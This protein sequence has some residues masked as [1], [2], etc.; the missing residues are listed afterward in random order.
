LTAPIDVELMNEM[1]RGMSP[2]RRDATRAPRFERPVNTATIGPAPVGNRGTT[3]GRAREAVSGEMQDT[4]SGWLNEFVNPIRL[5]A[6]VRRQVGGIVDDAANRRPGSAAVGA[7]MLG[8]DLAMPGPPMGPLGRR[9]LGKLPERWAVITPENPG[10]QMLSAGQNAARRDALRQRLIDMGLT[11]RESTGSYRDRATGTMLEGE[12]PF[13]IENITSSQAERLGR[14]FDQNAVLTH[15]GYHDLPAMSVTPIKKVR[16]ATAADENLTTIPGI[17]AMAVDLDGGRSIMRANPEIEAIWRRMSKNGEQFPKVSAVDEKAAAR[18]A[19]AYDELPLNDPAA[20]EG[21]EALAREVDAQFQELI[22]AGY[23]PVFVDEDPYKGP[24]PSAQMMQ[25]LRDNRSFRVYKTNDENPH[26]YLTKEQNDRF[27][28]VHDFL[29]HAGGGNQ[30]GPKGEENAYRIHAQTLSPLARRALATETRGQNSWVNYGPNKDLPAKDR[31]YAVQKAAL[32]PEE[33]TGDYSTFPDEGGAAAATPPTPP[34]PPSVVA[35]AVFSGTRKNLSSTPK[36]QSFRDSPAEV[37]ARLTD[38]RAR[39]DAPLDLPPIPPR[40][41][42]VD[43]SLIR[44]D[45]GP[46]RAPLPEREAV[47]PRAAMAH[48]RGNTTMDN[49]DLILRQVERGKK[50]GVGDTF[51]PS[52]GAVNKTLLGVGDDGTLPAL[53]SAAAIRSSVPMEIIGGGA[54]RWALGQGVIT[55]EMLDNA[56]RLGGAAGVKAFDDLATKVR[57]AFNASADRNAPGAGRLQL[58]GAHLQAAQKMLAGQRGDAYKIP[59]YHGQKEA[60]IPG[61]VLDTHEAKGGTMANPFHRLFADQSGFKNPEYG[62]Q[63]R[64][65][66]QLAEH[67]GMSDRAFQANRW[68]G[69]GV[70]TDLVTPPNMDYAHIFEDMVRRNAEARYGSTSAKNIDRVLRDFATGQVPMYAPKPAGKRRGA[71]DPRLLTTMGAPVVGAAVGASSDDPEI[72]AAQGGLFGLMAGAGAARAMGRTTAA[73]RLAKKAQVGRQAPL[74]DDEF[75]RAIQS[76]SPMN[77]RKPR[78]RRPVYE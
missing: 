7:A 66:R 43:P 36:Q 77:P 19:K 70:V 76:P 46:T 58:M 56:A 6:Q 52:A 13:F 62:V 78:P 29:A 27:R 4:P 67:T 48:M 23:T 35:P 40:A 26:P 34:V 38:A 31:P 65:Y 51:Y 55:K 25:D 24:N 3:A 49:V 22:D 14:E 30:F 32:F 5:G 53:M 9:A 59:T 20:R 21:Y 68:T 74:A 12:R 42:I 10:G 37:Q 60:N 63:E 64:L 57:T 47:G 15:R 2:G 45:Q 54:M 8:A 16:P 28:A 50:I 18:M 69:G 11:F 1:L 75:W 41:G 72:G 39:L 61:T 73:A 44:P 71:V 33:F 17:G